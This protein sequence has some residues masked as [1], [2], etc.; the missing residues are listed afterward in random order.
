MKPYVTDFLKLNGSDDGSHSKPSNSRG[1][2]PGDAD[3]IVDEIWTRTMKEWKA[4][5][6]DGGVRLVT[7]VQTEDLLRTTVVNRRDEFGNTMLHL[8]AWNGKQE[9]YDHLIALGADPAA[10]NRSG[11]TPFTLSIRF[12]LWDVANHIWRRHF[13]SVYW[14]FGN[15]MAESID[16][17][18]F[19]SA[20][21]GLA[22]FVSVLEIDFCLDALIAYQLS[23]GH[24]GTD[25]TSSGK[26]KDR[27]AIME[28]QVEA[29]V[30]AWCRGLLQRYLLE[31]LSSPIFKDDPTSTN[32]VRV[33]T[34]PKETRE[35]WARALTGK[36]ESS[37]P[38]ERIP[39]PFK[40]PARAE[41]VKSAVRLITMF[42]PEGWYEHWKD[43]MDEAILSK[44]SR[45]YY[46]VHVGDSLIPY[47][48]LILLFG[49]M[50]WQRR[51]DVLE[52]RFWWA[53]G[54]VIAPEPLHSVENACGWRSIRD[55]YS[56]A[57]QAVLVLYGV[58]SLLRLSMVQSRFRPTDL[59]EDVD[60]KI[61]AEELVNCAYLNLESVLHTVVAG[62]FF[63]IGVA[64]VAAGEGCDVGYIRT[65]KNATSIAAL[66]LFFNL[67]IL[68]KPYKGFG[69][70]VLTWYRFLLADLFNFLV[71]YSM[72]FIAFLIAIQTLHNANYAYIMWM[73]QTD[74]IFPRVEAAIKVQFPF[75]NEQG[76]NLTYLVNS[77]SPSWATQMLSTQTALDGCHSFRRTLVDTAFS[78]LEI[79]FGDG[80]ADALEQARIKPYNC[81]GFS[82]DNLLGY[83]LVL[84][85]FLTNTLIMNML[86]AMM[87]NTF[88]HQRE[89]LTKIW[90]LDISKRIMRYESSFPELSRRISRPEHIYSMINS[91]YW[92]T[93]LE[94]L[95]L[96]LYCVP[97]IHFV[98]L[99]INIGYVTFANAKLKARDEWKHILEILKNHEQ[100]NRRATSAC[101]VLC[102]DT[103]TNITWLVSAMH[104]TSEKAV[105][106]G[107]KAAESD[108]ES[109]TIRGLLIPLIFRLEQLKRV[110]GNRKLK[111]RD[112]DATQDK[113]TAASD[114][115]QVIDVK[116]PTSPDTVSSNIQK[117]VMDLKNPTSSGAVS[118]ASDIQAHRPSIPPTRQDPGYWYPHSTA[119]FHASA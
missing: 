42:R 78:L 39:D 26:S 88:D 1:I 23:K 24:E 107:Q 49:I 20:S 45:G 51:L 69:L 56:G 89:N 115:K 83:L 34:L 43:L 52:H 109:R 47:C 77:N 116:I 81:A 64:R 73:E 29:K 13:T 63:T 31:K 17:S 33:R 37:E 110:L 40:I 50:W 7:N 59:D 6:P 97:E 68:C 85:V 67:F 105:A 8:A 102:R 82:P 65:E 36:L 21:N 118:L 70:L 95:A 113:V 18:H 10:F 53:E 74:T 91:S 66:C 11:L 106:F 16:Y 57:I 87:S 46:L 84:W 9:M 75:A 44:W 108:P 92:M 79:S 112:I 61:T 55:S 54:T 80:L 99:I 4:I 103:V 100:R 5:L 32:R 25:L 12:G 38:R 96:I 27:M 98:A 94:D 15:V 58:P 28:R 104:S 76:G 119:Y 3:R 90:L 62:L 2:G 19:E 114:I 41:Q 60:W 93:K 48:L 111:T 35:L 117:Q 86:I 72:I 22:A 101:S 30:G 14:S 71:M